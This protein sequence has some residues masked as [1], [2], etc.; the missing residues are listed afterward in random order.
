MK[1][2]VATMF[3]AATLL[4]FP[5]LM[6]FAAFS[7]LFTMT[8]SNVVSVVL[9]LGFFLSAVLLGLSFTDIGM[10]VACSLGVLVLTFFFFA[11][12]WIGG[13]DAK[14]ASATALWIGFDHLLDY[15]LYAALIGGVLT[16]ALL[17]LRKWPLPS[18]LAA[19]RWVARLH[20]QATG[21]PYGIALA[22]AGLILYPDTVIWLSA[23]GR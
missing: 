20:D 5:A 2:E 23:T 13:G 3:Q 4:C 8:I 12:G 19:R 18:F 15:G 1:L 7:D 22:A 9:A 6:I 14:L 21:I 11:R 10:H 16:V 17:M